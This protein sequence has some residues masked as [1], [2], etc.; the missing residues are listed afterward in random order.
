ML[1]EIKIT[2]HENLSSIWRLC[3]CILHNACVLSPQ[4]RYT[5]ILFEHENNFSKRKKIGDFY[6]RL[7]YK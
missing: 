5:L 1:N 6:E 2:Y 7:I 4:F 3:L